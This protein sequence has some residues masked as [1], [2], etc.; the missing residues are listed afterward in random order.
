VCP[1]QAEARIAIVPEAGGRVP[2]DGRSQHTPARGHVRSRGGE[3]AYLGS[4]RGPVDVLAMTDAASRL[5]PEG[6]GRCNNADKCRNGL[7]A[8]LQDTRVDADDRQRAAAGRD[9]KDRERDHTK[10]EA[11]DGGKCGGSDR[12]TKHT[13]QHCIAR[14]HIQYATSFLHPVRHHTADASGFILVA[15]IPDPL[16]V[17]PKTPFCDG[18]ACGDSLTPP[19]ASGRINN[20]ESFGWLCPSGSRTCRIGHRPSSPLLTLCPTWS[21]RHDDDTALGYHEDLECSSGRALALGPPSCP[22]LHLP[23][24]VLVCIFHYVGEK[25]MLKSS[26]AQG[27]FARSGKAQVAREQL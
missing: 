14:F 6:A 2:H 19:Y 13:Y 7:D 4:C 12:V 21:A 25:G 1:R 3:R 9:D 24:R 11:K 15:P 18:T 27:R 23:H 17:P 20:V 5:R 22:R 10:L 16:H 26:A 8:R